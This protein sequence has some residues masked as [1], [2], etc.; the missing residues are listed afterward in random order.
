MA[1][2]ETESQWAMVILKEN[3]AS[4]GCGN[5]KRSTRTHEILGFTRNKQGI[6]EE[7]L[8]CKRQRSAWH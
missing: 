4:V 6:T 5:T 7:L 2:Y 3:T 1:V 8:P